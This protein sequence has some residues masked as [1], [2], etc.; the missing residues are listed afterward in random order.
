MSRWTL[1]WPTA[2]GPRLGQAIIR[3][4]PADF[5]VDETLVM[6]LSGEGEHLCV[7]LEKT[8]DNTR[9]VAGGLARIAGCRTGDIGYC[10]LKDRW[11]VTRQWFSIPWPARSDSEPL[12][13]A[14]K[15]EWSVLDVARH[16]RKLR[17]G[18]H[19]DNHFR[20]VLRDVSAPVS[21]IDARLDT[22]ARQGCPN[23]FGAQRFGHDGGNLDE[24]MAEAGRRP[25]KGGLY[26]SAARA[27][28]FN[29]VL[30][31][32]VRAG[33]WRDRLPGEPDDHGVTGPL[34]GDGGTNAT[35]E[36]ASLETAV[37]AECPELAAVFATSR[38]PPERRRLVLL[39][40]D[41]T[42]EW[43]AQDTLSLSFSLPPGA[44]ATSVLAELL[45]VATDDKPAA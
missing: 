4:S 1:D 28:L 12:I 15:S 13:R 27:W 41:L 10:G 9:Y 36:Q 24:A 7:R 39:L 2:A 29:A 3:R 44:F 16:E 6:P 43:P 14:I 21:D 18:D 42:W 11:A 8:G 38:M 45:A 22:L 19:A 37:V 20:L 26:R 32:R 33:N 40:P 34:W 30:A 5:F 35:G 25:R 23:Y 31:A 17:R